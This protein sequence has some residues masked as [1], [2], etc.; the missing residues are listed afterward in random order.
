[1]VFMPRNLLEHPEDGG[2]LCRAVT[3]GIHMESKQSLETGSSIASSSYLPPF[4]CGKR[5]SPIA[6]I[7]RRDTQSRWLHQLSYFTEDQA[8]QRNHKHTRQSGESDINKAH[9]E[10]LAHIY[11]DCTTQNYERV[12]QALRKDLRYR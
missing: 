9:K 6:A 5:P 2:D 11:T 10:Y 3:S 4:A 12:K 1:M 7:D 8:E